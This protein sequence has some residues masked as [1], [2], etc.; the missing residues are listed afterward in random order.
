MKS[1]RHNFFELLFQG[2]GR[3]NLAVCLLI[4]LPLIWLCKQ[5]YVE[6]FPPFDRD[7]MVWLQDSINPVF[8]P[9]FKL[10]YI[11]G[12]TKSAAIVVAI[13]LAILIWKRCWK[14]ATILAFG[15][16]GVLILVDDILKPFLGRR[17]PDMR[18]IEVSG[19]KSFPSGHATGNLFLYFYLSYL[20]AARFPQL[21]P[22]I[23]STATLFLIIMGLSSIYVR[24][25]WPTDI[26]AGYGIGYIWLTIALGLLKLSEKNSNYGKGK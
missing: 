9:F 11:I 2:I 18:L 16:V 6:K 26:L 15:S 17:R 5:I 19:S 13:S 3:I 1:K 25:H 23:Y 4:L 22:Y 20:L 10:F 8:N 12:S 7:L 14:Q 24:A 21:T